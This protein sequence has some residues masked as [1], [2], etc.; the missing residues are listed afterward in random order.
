MSHLIELQRECLARVNDYVDQANERWPRLCLQ[1]PKVMFNL[2]GST[3]GLA[4]PGTNLLELH[5]RYLL[6]NPDDYIKNTAGHE[7]AHLVA[8]RLSRRR[9]DPHGD[10]WI[11]VM[12]TFKLAAIRC[13]RYDTKP[14]PTQNKA[15]QEYRTEEGIIR[16]SHVGKIIEF[17]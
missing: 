14:H 15:K 10:E 17:D 12:W 11:Q 4:N 1:Y 5:N 7:V 13:H 16:P 9:V 3:A 6:E 8:R 2:T